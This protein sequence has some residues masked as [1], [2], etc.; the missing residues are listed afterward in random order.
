M[1]SGSLGCR[2]P[3]IDVDDG[4]VGANEN[5]QIVPAAEERA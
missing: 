5:K 1:R 4:I 2:E 3:P